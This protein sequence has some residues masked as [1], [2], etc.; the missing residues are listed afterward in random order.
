MYSWRIDRSWVTQC[1]T[2]SF[3]GWN[4]TCPIDPGWRLKVVVV[5]EGRWDG[6]GVG[7]GGFG[8]RSAPASEQIKV[9]PGIERVPP[10]MVSG[11]RRLVA[12]PHGVVRGRGLR[13]KSPTL[14]SPGIAIRGRRGW[15]RGRAS[16]SKGGPVLFLSRAGSTRRRDPASRV[17]RIKEKEKES[18]G[19]K[20]SRTILA[21]RDLRLTVSVT[22]WCVLLAPQ[23][24]LDVLPD[25]RWLAFADAYTSSECFATPFFLSLWILLPG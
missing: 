2:C 7:K 10:F 25:E 13:E 18:K 12:K 5:V 21:S 19:K 11:R 24:F 6:R 8:C 16:R 1:N 3:S 17:T 22:K 14:L 15:F 23:V 4:L 20:Y 9:L